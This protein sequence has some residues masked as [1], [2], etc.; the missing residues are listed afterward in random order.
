MPGEL[1]SQV[2]G[3]GLSFLSFK[4]YE[5]TF[6]FDYSEWSYASFASFVVKDTKEV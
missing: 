1:H 6:L 5:K 3:L 4:T 2:P